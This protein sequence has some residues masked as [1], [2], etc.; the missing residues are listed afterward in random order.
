MTYRVWTL[1][2]VVRKSSDVRARRNQCRRRSVRSVQHPEDDEGSRS[3]TLPQEATKSRELGITQRPIFPNLTHFT[4]K[5]AIHGKDT[6]WWFSEQLP[7]AHFHLHNSTW[8]LAALDEFFAGKRKTRRV[9]MSGL[10]IVE[11][12]ARLLADKDVEKEPVLCT[13]VFIIAKD[14]E[15]A[16]RLAEDY[17]R[18][19]LVFD[20]VPD[21][22][23][24]FI[25]PE[26]VER[27]TYFPL[28]FNTILFP[29]SR[30]A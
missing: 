13:D 5:N 12:T 29:R 16:R 15:E 24:Q 14:A 23:P 2:K 21:N 3:G 27:G 8:K 11:Y 10:C 30:K 20:D 22:E 4:I 7:S 6:A 28:V 1:H 26:E 18:Y 19:C 25:R 9:T 17:S